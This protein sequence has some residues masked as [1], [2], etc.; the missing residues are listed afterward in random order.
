M[1]V[2]QQALL[3]LKYSA[4][5]DLS[6]LNSLREASQGGAAE[7]PRVFDIIL[8]GELLRDTLGEALVAKSVSTESAVVL[9]YTLLAVPPRL[10]HST[11]Q[12]DWCAPSACLL[13]T[14]P[15]PRD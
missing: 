2:P 5:I 9:E 4:H 14:S 6:D 7:A 8:E 10:E 11:P 15:S 3:G 1:T 12:P 13:Y